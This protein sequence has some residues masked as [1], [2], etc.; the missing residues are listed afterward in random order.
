M[1]WNTEY[2]I[3]LE[4]CDIERQKFFRITKRLICNIVV[5]FSHMPPIAENTLKVYDVN[6]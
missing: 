3:S 6:Q 4:S 5:K 1:A 2:P